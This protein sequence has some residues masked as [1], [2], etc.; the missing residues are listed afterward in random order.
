MRRT[1]LALV[2]T[3][4]LSGQS[5]VETVAGSVWIFPIASGPAT[6]APLGPI[7]GILSD[8]AGNIFLADDLNRV[9]VRID[10]RGNLTTIAGNGIEGSSGEGLPAIQAQL[11]SPSSVAFD[12]QG[13]LLIADANNARIFRIDRTGTLTTFAGGGAN[14][15]DGVRALDAEITP[16]ALAVDSRGVVYFVERYRN[17]VRRIDTNG[18]VRTVAG[19][20]EEGFT[21][22]GSPATQSKLNG[23][24]GIA[25]DAAGLLYITDKINHRVRRVRA[26]GTLETIAGTGQPGT[27]GLNGPATRAGLIQPYGIHIDPQG[28]FFITDNGRNGRVLRIDSAGLITNPAPNVIID[29]PQGVT[30]TADGAIYVSETGT[31][32]VR[33]I[34][35]GAAALF[36]GNGRFQFAGDGGPAAAAALYN[37]RSLAAALDG[38]VFFVD[39]GNN[40]IR[41]IRPDGIVESVAAGA[42]RSPAGLALD[43]SGNLYV[44]EPEFG[45]IYRIPP[46]GARSTVL[47]RPDS[48]P[49]S[50]AVDTAGNLYFS[51]PYESAVRRIT[52]AGVESVYAGTGTAGFS[53]DGQAAIRA[54]LSFP[55]RIA[56]DAAGNLFIADLS[57]L[58]VRKVTPAGIIS[59]VAGNGIER[60]SGDGGPATAAGLED[61]RGLA[62]DSQNNLY[63]STTYRIRMVNST[64]II[65]TI[66]GGEIGGYFGDG[67]QPLE[68]GIQPDD[69]A[70]GRNGDL[71]FS[72]SSYSVIRA[73]RSAAP[74]YRVTPASVS[75]SALAGSNTVSGNIDLRGSTTA[76]AYTARPAGGAWL[77]VSTQSGQMPASLSV[78]ARTEGLQPGT[79]TARIEVTVPLGNPNRTDIPVTLTVTATGPKL[80]IPTQPLNFSSAENGSPSSTT[81]RAANEGSGSLTLQVQSSDPWLAVSPAAATLGAGEFQ[82]IQVTAN[83]AGLRPGT[84]AG[85]ITVVSGSDRVV[86]PAALII[87]PAGARILLS[88]TGLSFT[89]V[90][91]GGA[92]LAQAFGVLNEGSGTLNFSVTPT[93]LSGAGWLRAVPRTTAVERP[94]LDVAEVDVAVDHRGLA[95]GEYYGQIR[96]TSAGAPAAPAVVVVLR[97]LPGGSN[98]GPDV[99]PSGLIFSGSPGASPASQEVFVSNPLNRNISFASGSVTFDGTPWLRHLPTNAQVPPNDPR[100]IVVQ[101]NLSTLAPGIRRGAVTLVFDDGT[102]RNI[103]ILSIVSPS[104]AAA[105]K[106]GDRLATSCNSPSLNL[107]FTQIGDGAAARTGQPFPIELRAVDDCGNVVRGTERN[108]NTAAYAKFDNGDPDLRLVPLG[109]GRWTGTWRP[110]NGARDRVTI[111][112]VTVLVEGL[113]LQAGRVERQVSLTTSATT[114]VIRTGAVVHGASQRSDVPIAPGSLVTLYGANLSESTT[115]LNPLPLPTESQGT[116]VLLGGQSLPILFASPNQINA[117]LPF[118][119]PSNAALQ[120]VVRRRDQ[121]SVPEVFVVASAQPGIFTKNQQ[122]TGQGIVVRSDQITLAEPGTPARPGEAVV[123]YGTGLGPVS[124]P[125]AAGA[126]SPTSPLAAAISAITVTAGGKAAQVLFAGLTPGFAG[127]YQVNAI[128]APDTPS[129]NTVPLVI[130]VDGRDSNTVDIAVQN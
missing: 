111:T 34:A 6:Q 64:G 65:R 24:S 8:R 118:S 86:I 3:A 98:L 94:L 74:T 87:T 67:G 38:G 39:S 126:P 26:D 43:A 18:I 20:G 4:T 61:V 15:Q 89:A 16:S 1:L 47:S 11:G 60:F 92:P 105:D 84:Y 66:A 124:Q 51:D 27:D 5:Y 116:E 81:L 2:A 42:L 100:R 88:Q 55:T 41:R 107:T 96:V 95:P 109:D 35:N 31:R 112:G 108:V 70:I 113:T 75:L 83:P 71:Y 48:R 76:L 21:P 72:Q 46:S 32:T 99:I 33:R 93:T 97:V 127:L 7:E 57:N 122:G 25:V 80:S 54:Q 129:G 36:A 23:P 52:P 128:L 101:N 22:D 13:N 123:I 120:V 56:L 10:P 12:P 104:A 130:Q 49:D 77:Q 115:G 78:T 102:I 30:T 114:P 9:V 82:A 44:S 117:Q 110:L 79:Y 17:R 103:A 68:A 85:R 90:A 40:R 37:P 45:V 14:G 59:T 91:G 50:L 62:V 125:V 58:R 29:N 69:L 53:G 73:I 119:M 19:T 28:N 106:N 63:I 121:I